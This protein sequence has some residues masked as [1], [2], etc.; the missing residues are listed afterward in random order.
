MIVSSTITRQIE[1]ESGLVLQSLSQPFDCCMIQ[2]TIYY[3]VYHNWNNYYSCKTIKIW[4]HHFRYET[5]VI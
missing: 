1:L 2:G 5:H 4:K 3:T